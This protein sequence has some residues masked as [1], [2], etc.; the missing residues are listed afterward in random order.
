MRLGAADAKGKIEE[1][2]I[3]GEGFGAEIEAALFLELHG[4]A[5]VPIHDHR[6]CLVTLI[7]VKTKKPVETY[8]MPS[9]KVSHSPSSIPRSVH[10]VLSYSPRFPFL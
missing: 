7:D 6:G 2:R 9:N 3:L 8:P 5:Y 10:N 1:L 4:K